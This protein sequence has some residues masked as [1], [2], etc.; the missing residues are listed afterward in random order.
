MEGRR[1][2]DKETETTLQPQDRVLTPPPGILWTISLSPFAD[3]EIHAR[4]E[5]FKIC[6]PQACRPQTSWSQKVDGAAAH[7]PQSEECLQADH[8]PL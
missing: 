7:S 5:N 3:T 2:G 8:T 6:Y 4:W 1:S